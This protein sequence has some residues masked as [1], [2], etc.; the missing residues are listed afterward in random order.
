MPYN[1]E[2]SRRGTM[3]GLEILQVATAKTGHDSFQ[4]A[5][6]PIPARGL[7]GEHF[8][9]LE[10]VADPGFIVHHS[11]QLV[12]ILECVAL[13]LALALTFYSLWNSGT[14]IVPLTTSDYRPLSHG[15][16]DRDG[17]AAP[18]TAQRTVGRPLGIAILAIAVI[19]TVVSSFHIG[20]ATQ[21]A[22]DP[23]T[24][25][26]WIVAGIWACILL[27]STAFV[28]CPSPVS[29]FAISWKTGVCAALVLVSVLGRVYINILLCDHNVILTTLP[30]AEAFAGATIVI[31]CFLV[32]RRP[33]VLYKGTIV[34]R[35]FTTSLLG[36]ISFSWIET[37]LKA[38]EVSELSVDDLPE[39][40]H[41]SRPEAVY[42]VWKA[43]LASEERSTARGLWWVVLR[44]HKTAILT[45]MAVTVLQSFLSFVPQLAMMRIL[46]FLEKRRLDGNTDSTESLLAP[47][48]GLGLS[49]MVSATLETIKYWISY[50]ILSL[51]TRQQLSLAIFDKSVRLSS[52]SSSQYPETN[53]SDEGSKPV[54]LVA[55]DVQNVT[56]FLCFS[57]LIYECPLKIGLA[58]SFL[59]LL[60]GWQSVLAGLAVLSL[61][62]LLNTFAGKSYSRYQGLVMK[63]RDSRL[64]GVA[65]M[66][67]G[68]RQI[69]FSAHERRWEEKI[70]QLRDTEMQGQWIVCLWQILFVSLALVS[71]ILL[72][73][74]CLSVFVLFAGHLSAATAFTA[75]SVLASIE[76]AVTI[77][78]DVLSFL[79][80][81]RVS[82]CRIQSYLARQER[83]VRTIAAPGINF[84]D[85]TV[86]WPGC[87]EDG[88]G[89][90]KGLNL[91]FPRAALSIVTG[92][93]GSGKS[94]LL[95]AIL[96]EADVLGGQLSA[97][98]A[99]PFDELTTCPDPGQWL[100]DSTV[101]F[102]SQSP[103]L[104]NTTIR[105]S[106]LFGLP[107]DEMRYATTIFA[108]AL[109]ED[110]A[111]LPQKDQT[112][113]SGKGAN[114][115]GGQRWRIC[116][117]RALYS[118]ART[119]LMDD[120]FSAL[121]VHT[122][123]HVYRH[124]LCG[125]LLQRRT[126]ILVTHHIDL[127]QPLAKY[128]V[129][130]ENGRV[131]SATT[132]P[133]LRQMSID[134]HNAGGES[135]LP[136]KADFETLNG[137]QTVDSRTE[138]GTTKEAGKGQGGQNISQHVAP[139]FLK[140]GASPIQW[141]ILGVSFLAHGG[142][143]LSRAWWIHIWTDSYK[144]TESQHPVTY[145]L[146]IYLTL[147]AL[148]CLFGT[149]RT[150]FALS[151]ALRASQRLFRKMLFT[152]LQAPL[153]WHDSVRL[154]DILSRF[155]A[156]TNV[157][158]MR[159]GDDLRAT[160][161]YS[162]DV[163]LAVIAGA[164]VS[165]SFLGIAVVL[166]IV[167]LWFARRFVTASRQ[168]KS[169]E[170]AIKAPPLE[171]LDTT[172]SGLSTVRAFGHAD[173]A[174]QQF[175]AAVGRHAR[176][177]WHL[178]LLNRWLGIRI[179]VIGAIFSALSAAVVV[180]TPGVTP[181][182]AGF[183]ITFTI[184]VSLTMALSIRRYV[185]L[186][187]GLNSMTRIN[188]YASVQPEGN[189]DP[190]FDTHTDFLNTWPSQGLLEVSGL[191]VKHDAHLPP[192]L[193]GISF[194]AAPGSKI[195]IVGR[196]GAGKSSLVLALFRFLEATRGS[197]V[198]DGVNIANMS[199]H[200]LRSRLAIIPQNPVLF[201]GSIRTNL[202]PFK[203]YDS[204][205]L[206]TALQA[207][208]WN[209]A[210]SG[211][212]GGDSSDAPTVRRY[213]SCSDEKFLSQPVTEGGEN[214]S[215]GQRQLLCLARAMVRQPKIMILDEATASVDKDTDRLIQRS[216]RSAQ[217]LR[218][219]TLL[220]IAHRLN[221]IVD[222]DTV[223]VL[224]AG[225]IV[226]TGTPRELL[227]REQG[228]FRGMVE[229]DP[230]RE[231]LVEKILTASVSS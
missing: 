198:V 194:V 177:Y 46:V 146:V 176:A 77:L 137:S 18:E 147:S 218:Q 113:I 151:A 67:R 39:L 21:N 121:D 102:V 128:V 96:G 61:L 231:D 225:K 48:A 170:N 91:N 228:Y 74:T 178:W 138:P 88:P 125:R 36:W 213:C 5:A 167:Y 154:G 208:G 53:S 8:L 26:C 191:V 90:L 100:I 23:G 33:D 227:L 199:L 197:I 4:G 116:L 117:A 97:P 141:L 112:E 99:A 27:Q 38:A 37:V 163:A 85:V 193:H 222:V 12:M 168:L 143:M 144:E 81:A 124:V 42:N 50:N 188:A 217:G 164:I 104:Q 159:V 54:N 173:I 89:K 126:C 43:N 41:R 34:D 64:Q 111:T 150:Y 47:V 169:L 95:A 94:L 93:T 139:V 15:Y 6:C 152:V 216:L 214:L 184:E 145:Y 123:E 98:V 60:L 212:E 215:H 221:T 28:L 65:E 196:T 55:M 201:S 171:H 40:D 44:S 101:A 206:L 62:T 71:P 78:P 72:S 129:H 68:I 165:P 106:I 115:S 203:E 75:V 166:L 79:L 195:G 45:Q 156:D 57:F 86:A 19:G 200:H 207:V 135:A 157:L 180:Y 107:L 69:K 192:V 130:L 223:L 155:S 181:S 9:D 84:Q 7:D 186:E 132:Q 82:M 49:V 92:S 80:N 103:W 14:W 76:V 56:D 153:Q 127:C 10:S 122:R 35:Q 172:I 118:R 83:I 29:C 219:T 32:P 73:A 108:C 161:E 148:A 70:N 185:N 51:R 11:K 59:I 205:T 119:L 63:L 158:D 58:L 17:E 1:W 31:V 66:L 229:H 16:S 131:K 20:L 136:Y 174:M 190:A 226:E 224:D 230:D 204:A 110:F 175:S 183:A 189:Q 160:L 52:L 182:T 187:Q 140:E 149:C 105:E 211:T 22:I 133:Q 30:V 179:N 24:A 109:H 210:N 162:M 134:T 220:I 25:G 87:R 3:S 202:D 2:H 120:I 114:L 142:L 13:A 209:E